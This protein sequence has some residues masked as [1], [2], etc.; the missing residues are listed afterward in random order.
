MKSATEMIHTRVDSALKKD[1]TAILS[2]FGMSMSDAMRIFLS[3][4]VRTKSFPLELKIPNETTLAAMEETEALIK[5][6]KAKFSNAEEL[7]NALES[8]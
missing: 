3:Q 4:V 8:K 2:E 6:K 5:A 7:F 1:A